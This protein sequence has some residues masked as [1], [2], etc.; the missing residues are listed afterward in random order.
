[1]SQNSLVI[2]DGTGVEVLADINAALDT[3]NTLHAGTTAPTEL[4]ADMLWADTANNLLKIYHGSTW[5]TLGSLAANL[6]MVP[7]S[8]GTMTGDLILSGASTDLTVG[9]ALGVTGA[10]TLSTATVSSTLGVTGALTLSNVMNGAQGSNITAAAT[11]N[12]ATATGNYVEVTN[13][14]GTTTVTALGTVG[15][16]AWRMV[17][18]SVTG[19]S[20]TLTHNATSLILP[21]GQNI[22]V[23]D[24]DCALFV[25]LGSG[26]W[27]GLVYQRN[28]LA[29]RIWSVVAKSDNY[30]VTT[31]DY[32]AYFIFTQTTDKTL[33]LPAASTAGSGFIFG[34]SN[35][36]TAGT[37]I[38]IDGNASETIDGLT[39]QDLY[40]GS[41]TAYICNGTSWYRMET[42]VVADAP[43]YTN[44]APPFNSSGTWTVPAGVYSA[45][46]TVIGGGG[47]GGGAGASAGTGAT[48]GSASISGPAATLT[49]NGGSGGSG[50][51]GAGG[52]GGSGT[53]GTTIITG[54]TGGAG[55]VFAGGGG[56]GGFV[57]KVVGVTPGDTYTVTIN[58]AAT[59]GAAG[60]IYSSPTQ[61]GGGG[62]AAGASGGANNGGNATGSASGAGASGSGAS[63]GAAKTS[64]GD[65]NAGGES[66]NKE[67]GGG[68]GGAFVSISGSCYIG[69]AGG[70]AGAGGGGASQY[71][72]ITT[73]IGG[74]GAKG[75]VYIEW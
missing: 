60:T 39:T 46:F 55:Y 12:L 28:S 15:A 7:A 24:G 5:V 65:G 71:N 21:G 29:A 19:G 11:T 27:R 23:T 4:A 50:T 2:P 8:G 35:R 33:T 72:F 63:G 53:G 62:S 58:S 67:S 68:G 22:S 73:A 61:G 49:A 42:G 51:G 14:T 25:S 32:G 1:M 47:G 75:R 36:G 57:Q 26:N 52:A 66:S 31:S 13:T 10:T 44:S 20:V 59:G 54:G 64:A 3:L 9:G 16:G 40:P 74:A 69:G 41:A 45:R 43:S 48:G 34:I 6:G 30:T 17:R 56:G 38:T 37:K 18:F 70:A